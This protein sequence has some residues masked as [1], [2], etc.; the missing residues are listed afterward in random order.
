MVD[1]LNEHRKDNW[2]DLHN[3]RIIKYGAVIHIDCHLTLPWYL[4]VNEAHAE[5]DELSS[6]IKDEYGD[7][8]ELF[9][10]SDGCM[11]FS[12]P[13]CTKQDCPVRQHNFEKRLPG[14]LK[15]FLPIINIICKRI[16]L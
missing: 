1:V 7:S 16:K 8:M 4:N 12:C 10:H 5:I 14:R 15:I 13:I 6:F 2:V 9:V 3:L 11:N